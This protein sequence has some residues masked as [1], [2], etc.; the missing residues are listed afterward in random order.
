MTIR[1]TGYQLKDG[2]LVPVAKRYDASTEAKRA[3]RQRAVRPVPRK[4]APSI[5]ELKRQNDA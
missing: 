1:I 3:D 5:P 4:K 2:K